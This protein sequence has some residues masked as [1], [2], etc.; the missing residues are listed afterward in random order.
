[1]VVLGPSTLA[2]SAVPPGQ[3]AVLLCAVGLVGDDG[4]CRDPLGG[5]EGCGDFF[6]LLVP[7]FVRE[8]VLVFRATQR[9]NA[10]PPPP[11]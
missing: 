3:P 2:L 10:R 6:L 4:Q 8:A 7:D 5:E 9:T 1:M 11:R